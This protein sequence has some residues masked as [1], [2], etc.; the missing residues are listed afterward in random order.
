[1]ESVRNHYRSNMDVSGVA[2][3]YLQMVNIVHPIVK[4]NAHLQKRS[5]VSMAS[6]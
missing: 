1:M 4:E 2:V 6:A 5:S 3:Q